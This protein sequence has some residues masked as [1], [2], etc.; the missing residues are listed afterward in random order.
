M[1]APPLIANFEECSFQGQCI[2]KNTLKYGGLCALVCFCSVV[3]VSPELSS[4][5]DLVIQMSVRRAPSAVH[6][7]LSGAY[8][9]NRMT[10]LDDIW[11]VG[12]SRSEVAHA[13]FWAWQMPIKYLICIIYAKICLEHFSGTVCP[14]WMIFGMWVGL[15]PKVRMVTLME[16]KGHQ[17]S[18]GVNYV[19]WL[20]YLVKRSPDAS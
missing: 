3:I 17:K 4:G 6:G 19:L 8:L 15:G 14:T 20:P 5:R 12:G 10:Y 11:Y 1:L 18:N 7:F 9:K 2:L 13:E 16:I